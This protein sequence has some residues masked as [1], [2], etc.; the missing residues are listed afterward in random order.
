MTEVRHRDYRSRDGRH[1]ADYVWPEAGRNRIRKRKRVVLVGG[2][3]DTQYEGD[4]G[5]ILQEIGLK[6]E[7]QQQVERKAA[8]EQTGKDEQAAIPH[9]GLEAFVCASR[10]MRGDSAGRRRDVG[11]GRRFAGSRNCVEL[12][13]HRDPATGCSTGRVS[14]ARRARAA[15]PASPEPSKA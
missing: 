14:R 13:R 15:A 1:Q 3:G 7:R 2:N 6:V 11:G 8:K 4:R 9:E 12:G 5:E 10:H